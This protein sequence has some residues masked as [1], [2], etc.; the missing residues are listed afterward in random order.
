M[1]A[2]V[3]DIEINYGETLRQR[4]TYEAAS[5]TPLNLT[6]YTARL[7]VTKSRP[8][9]PNLLVLT[10]ENGGIELGGSTG[11][12][13]LYL[14][15]AAVRDLSFGSAAYFLELVNPSGDSTRILEG[16]FRRRG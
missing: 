1:S 16:K 13:E 7:R 4:F 3:Y 2:G 11:W 12:I 8:S 15:D 14:S 6:G 5:G 10:T 9:D